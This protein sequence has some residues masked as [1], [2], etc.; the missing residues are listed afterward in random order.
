MSQSRPAKAKCIVSKD[1]LAF[2]PI[3]KLKETNQ[4]VQAPVLSEER[5]D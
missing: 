2:S 3:Q 4:K 1:V 5:G